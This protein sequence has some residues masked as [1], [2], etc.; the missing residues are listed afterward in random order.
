MF[1]LLLLLV[2]T[3][4][5]SVPTLEYDEPSSS[6][7]S[8]PGTRRMSGNPLSVMRGIC[9]TSSCVIILRIAV[10]FHRMPDP[11]P[12]LST[13]LRSAVNTFTP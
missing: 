1:A 3:I 7:S 11:A 5:S 6:V 10:A 12:C 8:F 13:S 2:T 4:V 9:V